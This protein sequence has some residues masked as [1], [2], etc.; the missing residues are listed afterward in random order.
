[1]LRLV[2][3]GL[4]LLSPSVAAALTWGEIERK[5]SSWW[6][7][8]DAHQIGSNILS[9]QSAHGS[10]PKNT[11]TLS[12][13]YAGSS[14]ALKG[15]FDNSATTRELRFLAKLHQV[16]EFR[17]AFLRGYKHV[18]DA[19]YTNGGW[20][21]SY[22]A[23]TNSY[24]RHITFNDNSM[25]R[26]L[27]FLRESLQ[28]DFLEA[29]LRAQA[30]QAFA[31]GVDCILKCQVRVA[32]EL[33]V[34]CAQ[35]DE[36]TLQ[37]RPARSYEL[38]SL[39]GAESAGLVKFLMSINA[40]SRETKTAIEA[41][42]RWFERAKLPGIKVIQETDSRSP[43]GKNKV[44]VKDSSAPPMWARFYEIETA[45]PIFVDR[46]GIKKYDLS[47]IGYER[48]NGYAWLG[49][50]PAEVI[51]AYVDWRKKHQRSTGL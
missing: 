38:I 28:Y 39:S 4:L 5:P 46:D 27:E 51:E 34:W 17:N 11:D 6:Q 33:T 22:P 14:D 25:V 35:H 50:W 43:T 41:A 37:P 47:E 49:Y 7:S 29:A 32:G 12:K 18:L 13:P 45:R 48:R 31:R 10:W 3:I 40:P 9:W 8:D 26:I 30:R 19:Q 23:P 24:A 44:I 15:T 1:M 20:P 2:I 42:I 21:Q 36:K 16:P